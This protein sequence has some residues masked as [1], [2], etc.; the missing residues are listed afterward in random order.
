VGEIKLGEEEDWWG[1][2]LRE[3]VTRA[4]EREDGGDGGGV[5]GSGP[6]KWESRQKGKKFAC[7]VGAKTGLNR[8]PFRHDVRPVGLTLGRLFVPGL[9]EDVP[10]ADGA[11]PFQIPPA[12]D[13]HE[14]FA[15]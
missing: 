2:S 13:R 5:V 11:V 15:P 7:T 4:W 3:V 9:Q 10:D 1:G 12:C 6:G 8:L 14:C